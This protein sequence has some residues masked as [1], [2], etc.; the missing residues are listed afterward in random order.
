MPLRVDA[1]GGQAR[2]GGIVVRGG[3]R[4]QGGVQ[5]GSSEVLAEVVSSEDEPG[6]AQD[7]SGV[8]TARPSRSRSMW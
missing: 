3:R 2:L 6:M 8:A 4:R 5:E 1:T 7:E